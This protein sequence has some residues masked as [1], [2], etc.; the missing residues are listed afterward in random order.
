MSK[1]VRNLNVKM[2]YKLSFLCQN[3]KIVQVEISEKPKY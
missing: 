3:G 2:K 1:T